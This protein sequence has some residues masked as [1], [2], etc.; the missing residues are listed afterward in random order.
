MRWG[1]TAME[2]LQI[3]AYS[4]LSEHAIHFRLLGKGSTGFWIGLAV[5]NSGV[6]QNFI[7]PWFSERMK[8][9]AANHPN[10]KLHG[11]GT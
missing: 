3:V 2:G 8:G 6:R 9:L 10:S 5:I 4:F 11:M 1:G 7:G